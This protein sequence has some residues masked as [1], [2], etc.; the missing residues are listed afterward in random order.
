MKKISILL[1][2][3][4]ISTA[5]LLTSCS[6]DYPG[7]DPVDVTANYSNKFSNPNSNLSLYYSGEEMLGKSV[8][9]STVKGETANITLYDII[10]GEETLKLVSIPLIGNDTSYSFSGNGTGNVTGATFNYNGYVE[11]GKLTINLTNIKMGNSSQWAHSY[12]MSELTYGTKKY[13]VRNK[14]TGL[15]E[16]GEEANKLTTTA[17][18]TDMDIN[19]QVDNA[20][21]LYAT[22]TDVIK[23]FGGYMIA[24]LL[25]SVDI[26]SNGNIVAYY[27]TDEVQIGELKISEIDMNNKEAMSQLMTFIMQKLYFPVEMGGGFT[28]ADIEA[29]TTG[30]HY[31]SSSQGLAY[32]Y[33]KDGLFYI[34]LNIPAII[35]KSMQDKGKNVDYNLINTVTDALLKSNPSQLQSVLIT[36]NKQLNNPI[37][38][39]ITEIDDKDFQAIFV[40]IKNGIPMH[41]D[42]VN[43]HTYIYADKSVLTPFINIL[44]KMIPTLE[45]I[46][47][48]GE[49]LV[50]SYVKPIIEAWP[51]IKTVNIGL[52]TQ[53]KS[54]TKH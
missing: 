27:T 21:F 8:D 48:F 13:P 24:Q 51:V 11:K 12:Q 17:L 38:S 36:I 29:V 53:K 44:A 22:I 16:W 35:V 14:E 39:L 32:W 52:D 26:T 9:F 15:Y 2:I 43:E 34:K 46:P 28:A 41:L 54:E 37:L 33:S 40:W 42:N 45:A 49:L 20:V 4:F 30:R 7:P 19:L 5:C 47:T 3:S 23:G 50:A 10:P 18:Y 25:Q 1:I 31:T 6:E